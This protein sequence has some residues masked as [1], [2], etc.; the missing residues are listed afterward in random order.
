MLIATE[1]QMDTTGKDFEGVFVHKNFDEL[2]YRIL[3]L[4]KI[5]EKS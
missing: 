4:G 3:S 1:V 5:M 2:S